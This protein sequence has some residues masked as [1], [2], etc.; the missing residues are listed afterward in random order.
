MEGANSARFLQLHY[1]V[2]V[3]P[4]A[5]WPGIGDPG[6]SMAHLRGLVE[7]WASDLKYIEAFQGIFSKR[8]WEAFRSF[9]RQVL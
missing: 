6:R 7:V 5:T 3:L 2:G 1:L 4:N 9:E 8:H